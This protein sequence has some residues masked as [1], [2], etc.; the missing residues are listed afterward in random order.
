MNVKLLLDAPEKLVDI[1]IAN[2]VQGDQNARRFVEAF[3]AKIGEADE[4]IAKKREANQEKPGAVKAS[5]KSQPAEKPL[6]VPFWY[7]FVPFG[8]IAG[9][10]IVG[11]FIVMPLMSLF[12]VPI[13]GFFVAIG[14]TA[15]GWFYARSWKETNLPAA[16]AAKNMGL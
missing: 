16:P 13:A 1:I 14:V 2:Y 10:A 9:A 4:A 8:I 11:F 15:V 3:M 5:V 6:H 12:I 7:R